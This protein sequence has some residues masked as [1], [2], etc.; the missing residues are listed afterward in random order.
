MRR[1]GTPD[2]KGRDGRQWERKEKERVELEAVISLIDLKRFL[3]KFTCRSESQTPS[4]G[5]VLPA[6][7]GIPTECSSKKGSAHTAVGGL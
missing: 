1:K 4:I 5:H 6:E 7:E 3:W 2:R